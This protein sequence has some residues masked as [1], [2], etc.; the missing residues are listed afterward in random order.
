MAR[1]ARSDVTRMM[2]A[3]EER[4]LRRYYGTINAVHKQMRRRLRQLRVQMQRLRRK[5]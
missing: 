3:K 1:R 2:L 5:R 4:D